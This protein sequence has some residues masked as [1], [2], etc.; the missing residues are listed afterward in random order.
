MTTIIQGA[1]NFYGETL[2]LRSKDFQYTYPDRMNLRPGSKMHTKLVEHILSRSRESQRV[3]SE[4]YKSWDK[5]ANSL[6]AYTTPVDKKSKINKN[7]T[8]PVIVPVS[9]ATLETLLTYFTSAFLQD[10]IFRYEGVGPEDVTGAALLEY[11]IKKHTHYNTVG[12]N[13]HTQ[14]RDAFSYGFGVVAPSWKTDMGSRT[15]TKDTGFG[16][17]VLG[18]FIK[19]GSKVVEENVTLFE[20]NDLSNI[21]PYKYLPDVNHPI[22][23]VQKGEYVGFID[24][25]TRMAL[26]SEEEKDENLFNAKYLRYMATG[27]SAITKNY[28][29]DNR[30]ATGQTLREGVFG[31]TMPIDVI[32]MY[33]TL[34][35]REFGLGKGEYPEKWKFQLA[36][37][38]IILEARPLGLEHDRYPLAVAA[39]DFDGYATNPASRLE[40]LYGMQETIDWL[41]S[42]HV[43]NVKKAINDMYVV[44][45][46]MINTFDLASPRPGKIIRTR[47]AMWGRGVKEGLMQL[48]VQDVTQNHMRDTSLIMDIINRTSAAADSMQGITKKGGSR[49]S[50]EEARNAHIGALSRIEKAARIVGMQSMQPLGYMFAK[51]TQQLM[52]EDTYI[53]TVGDYEQQLVN[54]YGLN[55]NNGRVKVRPSDISIDFDIMPHDGTMPGGEPAALWTNLFQVLGA[56]PELLAQF[57]V[58]RIFMHIARQLGAKNA[59]EFLRKPDT[60]MFQVESD[61]TVEKEVGKGNLA[62][63]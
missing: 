18:Q 48:N 38:S 51:H 27:R 57:D 28:R 13:L 47:R 25:T 58:S 1:E 14:W 6:R 62:Q 33:I 54:E 61:E 8:A 56:S 21:D 59:Y 24:L 2:D 3:M 36:G 50:A 12:L 32:H 35:P 39:P 23:E 4:R 41:F 52:E 49:V 22:H 45:P 9:Y 55:V 5:I 26:L 40:I 11:I 19:T 34:V 42:S 44:D 20:G 31:M 10:T 16:S 43:A 17:E 60:K 37:D 30:V 53:K 63:V 29:K 7:K 15:V 46:S